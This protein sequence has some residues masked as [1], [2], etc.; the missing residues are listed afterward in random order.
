[1]KANKEFKIY[2]KNMKDDYFN[3]LFQVE[4]ILIKIIK[5]RIQCF[6][7]KTKQKQ[8]TK[9]KNTKKPCFSNST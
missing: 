2:L 7:I 8:E 5:L 9:K 1:M 6:F 3:N 4:M